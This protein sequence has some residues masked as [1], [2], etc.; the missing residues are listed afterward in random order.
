M[1]KFVVTDTRVYNGAGPGGNAKMLLEGDVVSDRPMDGVSAVV[2]PSLAEQL[3]EQ[4]L[5]KK[6]EDEKRQSKSM[7]RTDPA[8][9]MDVKDEVRKP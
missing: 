4:G 7:N 6:I 9:S 8:R 2:A 5:L 1:S 3:V